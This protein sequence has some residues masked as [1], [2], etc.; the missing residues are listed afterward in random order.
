MVRCEGDRGIPAE[1]CV[2]LRTDP[3][4]GM[5]A[6]IGLEEEDADGEDAPFDGVLLVIFFIIDELRNGGSLLAPAE[7]EEADRGGAGVEDGVS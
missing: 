3:P 1:S 4:I 7:E 6:A 2:G 5:E